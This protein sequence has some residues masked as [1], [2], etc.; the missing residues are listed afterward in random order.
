MHVLSAQCTQML[1][2]AKNTTTTTTT[3]N[4]GLLTRNSPDLSH[5]VLYGESHKEH[6]HHEGLQELRCTT[7]ERQ[8]THSGPTTCHWDEDRRR[9]TK[10]DEDGNAHS[11]DER[12]GGCLAADDIPE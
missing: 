1:S 9:Q 8:P 4:K 6:T 3:N 5:S 11:G 7:S 12:T 10:T 2:Q